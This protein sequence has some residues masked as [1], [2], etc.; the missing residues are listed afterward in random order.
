MST[1]TM[2]SATIIYGDTAEDVSFPEGTTV[3][4]LLAMQRVDTST[5]EYVVTTSD[6]HPIDQSLAIGI[7]VPSGLLLSVINTRGTATAHQSARLAQDDR[8]Y[9]SA[10]RLI[11]TAVAV[12]AAEILL[13][14]LPLAWPQV[15]I[16]WPVRLAV[17]V[18]AVAWMLSLVAR[19]SYAR[20]PVGLVVIPA[21]VGTASLALISSPTNPYAV[22][23]GVIVATCVAFLTSCAMSLPAGRHSLKV[24][25][26]GW[27]VVAG[28]S[29]I[30]LS[31][32]LPI[33]FVAPLF[34]AAG[35]AVVCAAPRASL[36]IPES[37][38][39]DLPLLAI[40]V[41]SP[42]R[43][44]VRPPSSITVARVRNTLDTTM[45]SATFLTVGGCLLAVG[46][47][48]F[49]APER[50][51][52]SSVRDWGTIGLF[53]CSIVILVLCPLT[54]RS[55]VM[56]TVP[57][58]AAAAL[59]VILAVSVAAAQI[60]PLSDVAVGLVVLGV[61]VVLGK[62]LTVRREPS[63]LLG[64]IGDIVCGFTAIA[65]AP[66]AVLASGLFDLVW[67]AAS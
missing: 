15:G 58:V 35:V 17:A 47:G 48:V 5:G 36:R 6:G 49:A 41:D 4:G 33:R 8:W 22:P 61:L 66:S 31:L 13:L 24:V 65:L 1:A 63:A 64:R 16:P 57:R 51:V 60:A 7:D 25:V 59:V 39:V 45:L 23:T 40:A 37:Q 50:L 67:Q 38:L 44:A 12:L 14:V 28:A 19:T 32:G 34:L 54:T 18:A 26:T 55:R 30:T 42:R 56:S 10:T 43:P 11:G 3:S 21:G 62:T 9:A 27:G 52:M 2:A 20:T 29:A 53:V 46:M